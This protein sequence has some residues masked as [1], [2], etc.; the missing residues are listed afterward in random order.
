VEYA[1]GFQYTECDD[2]FWIGYSIYDRETRYINITRN[3]FLSK[4]VL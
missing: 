2:S 1:L 4:M 3:Y